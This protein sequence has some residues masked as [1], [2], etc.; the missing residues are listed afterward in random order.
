MKKMKLFAFLLTKS[1]GCMLVVVRDDK[2]ETALI[3][4]KAKYFGDKWEIEQA[5][6]LRT[7]GDARIIVE[8]GMFE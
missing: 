6:E 4:V 3:Q 1:Y 5:T 2:E 7:D 8:G